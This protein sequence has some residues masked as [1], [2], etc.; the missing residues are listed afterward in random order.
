MNLLLFW[1]TVRVIISAPKYLCDGHCPCPVPP[2]G[3]V[4]DVAGVEKAEEADDEAEAE[5]EEV[6]DTMELMN[7]FENDMRVVLKTAKETHFDYFVVGVFIANHF[8]S[9]AWVFLSYVFSIPSINLLQQPNLLR[10]VTRMNMMYLSL[11]LGICGG[12]QLYAMYCLSNVF[13]SLLRN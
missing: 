3:A 4:Q 5:A 10:S 13:P 12:S 8:P 2:P 6:V 1:I 9:V 11:L 7:R